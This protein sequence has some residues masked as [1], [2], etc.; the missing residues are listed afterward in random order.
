M[1]NSQKKIT[2]YS[3]TQVE[4][5]YRKESVEKL[6]FEDMFWTQGEGKVHPCTGAEALYKQYGP[7]GE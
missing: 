1:R 6:D 7:Q 4:V 5:S 3:E 2:C